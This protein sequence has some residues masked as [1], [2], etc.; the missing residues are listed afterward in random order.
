MPRGR[1][2]LFRQS[3]EFEIRLYREAGASIARLAEMW[4]TSPRRIHEILARQ[5]ARLGPEKLP[6]HKRHLVR[7]HSRRSDET[8]GTSTNT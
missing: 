6:Q 5:R 4:S 7:L 2:P 8:P 3:E 1:P